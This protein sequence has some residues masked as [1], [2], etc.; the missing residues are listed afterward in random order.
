MAIVQKENSDRWAYDI[1]THII[2]KGE[3]YDIDAI[4][5][6]IENILT[7]VIG[8]RIFNISFGSNLILRVF[9]T[10]SVKMGESLLDDISK[11]IQLWDDRIKVIDSEM[12]LNISQDTNSAIIEIPYRVKTTGLKSVFKKKIIN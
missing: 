8:E 12:R 1:S 5:Q 2:S 3:T 9:E 10:A 11:T 7:T 4:N 6:S